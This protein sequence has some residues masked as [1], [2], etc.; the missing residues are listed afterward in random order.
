MKLNKMKI[1]RLTN[2]QA[3]SIKGGDM[4]RSTKHKFTCGWCTGGDSFDCA[5]V[6]YN[7]DPNC[8]TTRP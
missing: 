6:D 1:A 8:N 7:N 4:D 5:T 2:D 3:K